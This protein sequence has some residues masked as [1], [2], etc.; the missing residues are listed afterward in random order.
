MEDEASVC[1]TVL[2]DM[3]RARL[4]AH[5]RQSCSDDFGL[6]AFVLVRHC[7]LKVPWPLVAAG[8]DGED[9]WVE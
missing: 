8:L 5:K 4:D 7:D 6:S 1:S 2:Q 9:T 3:Q